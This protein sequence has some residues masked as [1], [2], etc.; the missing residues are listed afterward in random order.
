MMALSS[1]FGNM[2]SMP[3]ASVFLPFLPMTAPQILL[4]NFLYDASQLAIP[5][6]T[7]DEDFLARP[8]KFDIGFMKKFMIIFGPL[9][10]CFDFLTFGVL[11]FVF[12]ASGAT[13]QTGWFLESIATQTLVVLIIRSRGDVLHASRPSKLLLVSIFGAVIVG[14]GIT[15]SFLGLPFGF[16]QFS[17]WGLMAIVAIVAVYLV[18]VEVAKKFFYKKYGE[19]IEKH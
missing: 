3:I 16:T 8:K 11:I 15:Y 13:F 17:L 4:N 7:V 10:S 18:V 14:W 9:S 19:L 12:H 6:D 2:F 1:N 5:F